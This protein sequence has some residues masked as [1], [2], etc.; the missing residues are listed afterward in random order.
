VHFFEQLLPENRSAC[1]DASTMNPQIRPPQSLLRPTRS[2]GRAAII[3]P[4]RPRRGE[5]EAKRKKIA[6][7]SAQPIEKA[8]FG[9]EN[10]TESKPFSLIVFAPFCPGFA[11][12][13]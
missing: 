12:F 6:R 13:C 4:P 3:S 8:R 9:Q 1:Y 7:G 10:A 2:V 5:Q 11:G